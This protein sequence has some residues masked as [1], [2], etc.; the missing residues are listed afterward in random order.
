MF[1]AGGAPLGDILAVEPVASL[2]NPAPK[3]RWRQTQLSAEYLTKRR[4]I[5]NA[6][7]GKY[8]L[9]TEV[10]IVEKR[11]R[12]FNS[13]QLQ[14]T[15]WSNAIAVRKNPLEISEAHRAEL[16]HLNNGDFPMQIEIHP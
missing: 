9:K 12:L 2:S 14:V 6:N 15:F 5:T 13:F 3:L 1:W 7:L 4:K 11:F 10:R 8:F 16:G